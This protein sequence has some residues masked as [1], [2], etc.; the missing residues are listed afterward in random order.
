MKKIA[1]LITGYEWRTG[2]GLKGTE[3][4]HVTLKLGGGDTPLQKLI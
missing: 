2:K 1:T 3:S 4:G